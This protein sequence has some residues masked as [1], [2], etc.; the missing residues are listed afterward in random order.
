VLGPDLLSHTFYAVIAFV[1]LLPRKRNPTSPTA[2]AE[3]HRRPSPTHRHRRRAVPTT[4]KPILPPQR[5]GRGRPQV[6]PVRRGRARGSRLAPEARRGGD[7]QEAIPGGEG[8]VRR[9]GGVGVDRG[10]REAAGGGDAGRGGRLPHGRE[11]DRLGRIQARREGGAEEGVGGIGGTYAYGGS[12]HRLPFPFDL[13]FSEMEERERE[14]R[15]RASGGERAA[16]ML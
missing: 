1:V 11:D 10:V 6:G 13:C 9:S 16:S 12:R 5:R 3:L 15:G 8:R 4:T 7:R 2:T 14:K